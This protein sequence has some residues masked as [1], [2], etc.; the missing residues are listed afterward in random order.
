[1]SDKE[2]YIIWARDA[3][4][5]QAR[6]EQITDDNNYRVHR[7]DDFALIQSE[8]MDNDTSLVSSNESYCIVFELL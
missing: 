8:D 4:K 2:L 5:A 6:L 7:R 1:M 3:D